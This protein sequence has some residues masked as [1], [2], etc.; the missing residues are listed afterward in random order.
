M[1]MLLRKNIFLLSC[2]FYF[3]YPSYYYIHNGDAPT[4]N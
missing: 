2:V 3:F 4:E 1:V